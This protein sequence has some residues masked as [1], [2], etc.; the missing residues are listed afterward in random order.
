MSA[1]EVKLTELK[2][3]GAHR[4][5]LRMSGTPYE[6]GQP[7]PGTRIELHGRIVDGRNM[8]PVTDW[9]HIPAQNISIKADANGF[10]EA[11][12]T[13]RLHFVDKVLAELHTINL[14]AASV[15]DSTRGQ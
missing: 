2:L 6:P 3:D 15:F 7:I 8:N 9:I 1:D 10:A 4:I 11:T 12:I 5:E 14:T 13:T